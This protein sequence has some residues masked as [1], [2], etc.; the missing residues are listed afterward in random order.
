MQK[1]NRQALEQ[2]AAEALRVLTLQCFIKQSE[3]AAL[4]GVSANSV[5]R[6]LKEKGVD[7]TRFGYP[8]ARVIDALD[9]RGYLDGLNKYFSATR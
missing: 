7:R 8:T 9:L 6:E 1:Q 5:G 2:S 3:L 4:L